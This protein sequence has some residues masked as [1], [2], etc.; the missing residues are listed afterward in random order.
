MTTTDE[1]RAAIVEDLTARDTNNGAS[2]LDKDVREAKA[3]T[4][5][6][7][8]ADCGYACDDPDA[9]TLEERDELIAQVTEAQT[10]CDCFDPE[11][12]Y[13]HGDLRAGWDGRPVT[14]VVTENNPTGDGECTS[15]EGRWVDLV[16]SFLQDEFER[17]EE[18]SNA[19]W[20]MFRERNGATLLAAIRAIGL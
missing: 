7:D 18:Y 1:M 9:F 17:S 15:T 8:V 19:G 5:L 16:R 20:R 10:I 11:C 2:N 3:L 13:P 12:G 6:R 14:Q 4:A